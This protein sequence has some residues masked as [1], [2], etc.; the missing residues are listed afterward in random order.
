M[1]GTIMPDIAVV[2]RRWGRE[3]REKKKEKSYWCAL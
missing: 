3:E 2:R 1:G